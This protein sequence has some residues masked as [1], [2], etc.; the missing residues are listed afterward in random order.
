MIGEVIGFN[1][2][3]LAISLQGPKD[4]TNRFQKKGVTKE[5]SGKLK[6]I[7]SCSKI[8]KSSG[9]A[10]GK[11]SQILL[12]N[13]SKLIVYSLWSICC[14]QNDRLCTSSITPQGG[15]TGGGEFFKKK[16]KKD[17]VFRLEKKT[18]VALFVLTKKVVKKKISP[19]QIQM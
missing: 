8:A 18:L 12:I 16:L 10:D 7:E 9:S 11:R 4:V 2:K 1:L 19:T 17:L 13:S 14:S 6:K 5:F 3:F 15:Q